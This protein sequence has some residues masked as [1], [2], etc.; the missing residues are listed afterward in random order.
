MRVPELRGNAWHG[1]ERQGFD[2]TRL[3]L[4]NRFQSNAN[5]F[6]MDGRGSARNGKVRHGEDGHCGA[7]KG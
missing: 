6:Y 5:I 7:W 3:K 1:L 2:N 4:N